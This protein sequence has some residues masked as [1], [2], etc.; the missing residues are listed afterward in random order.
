MFIFI[1]IF[2]HELG[3]FETARIFK[4]EV[5]KIYLYPTGG[6]SK[7]TGRINVSWYKDLLVLING[8][9]S[10]FIIYFILVI[11]YPYKNSIEILKYIHY[12]ILLFNLLPIYPLDGGK[13]INIL[14]NRLFSF[15][16]SFNLTIIFSYIFIFILLILINFSFKI[17]Y[18]FVITF[19]IYKVVE[20]QTKFRYYYDKFLL[21]RYLYS[22][23]FNKI[24]VVSSFTK[25]K[26]NYEHIIKNKRGVFLEKEELNKK[27]TNFL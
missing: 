20:E 8:P 14:F 21:E 10:Q 18:L 23:S 4:F 15:R 11:F 17:N 25:K 9:L 12:S 6:I 13:I 1:L 19:L 3:H 7:F 26:K 16:T 2:V 5:D 22:F 27:F 24:C